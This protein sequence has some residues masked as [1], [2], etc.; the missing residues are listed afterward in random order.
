MVLEIRKKY[1]STY[2]LNWLLTAR[3]T[4]FG[5][6]EHILTETFAF[7]DL[8]SVHTNWLCYFQPNENALFMLGG[9]RWKNILLCLLVYLLGR[10]DL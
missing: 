5:L 8:K 10:S 2:L 1:L 3:L 6:P 9:I 4:D 7:S